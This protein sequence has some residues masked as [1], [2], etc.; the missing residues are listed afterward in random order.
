MKKVVSLLLLVVLC[1]GLCACEN[2]G[3]AS[4]GTAVWEK[5][6]YLDAFNDPTE[7]YYIGTAKRLSGS[8]SSDSVTDGKLEAEL[9]V[10][11]EKISVFLYENGTDLVKNGDQSSIAFS[12]QMKA[13]DGSKTQLYGEMVSGGACVEIWEE[14]AR[15]VLHFADSRQTDNPVAAALCAKNGEVSFYLTREDQPATSY[16]FTVKTGNFA[17]LYEAEIVPPIQEA[18]YAKAEAL[19]A[20]NE[21]DG[22]ISWF[23]A[24]GDYRDSPAR[25]EEADAAKTEAMNAAQYAQAEA[26]LK[27]KDFDGAIAAFTALGDYRDSAARVEEAREAKNADAYTKA[28][29]LLAAKNYSGAIAAF[30]ALGDYRDSAQRVREAAEKQEELRAL[31]IEKGQPIAAGGSHTVGLKADGTVVAVGWNKFGQC[32]VSGWT[33]IRLP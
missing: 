5:A 29:A 24:L 19:L 9:R 11:A 28:E 20:Q 30:T 27:Q 7:E 18:A 32:E 33:D 6:Y 16:L 14:Q 12:V 13:A 10:D 25:A 8:Y 22:A 4:L 23:T 21:Y 3:G 26:L 15:S 17:A 31:R 1:L 2:S